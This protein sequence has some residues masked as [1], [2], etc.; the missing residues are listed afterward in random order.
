MGNKVIKDAVFIQCTFV[1]QII[2][3]KSDTTWDYEI[4]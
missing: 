2:F 4:Y 1:Q 3:L